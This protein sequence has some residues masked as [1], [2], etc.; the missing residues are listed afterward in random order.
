VTSSTKKTW[1]Y[2]IRPIHIDG[3]VAFIPLT[4]GKT[5]IIDAADVDLVKDYNWSAMPTDDPEKW[6]AYNGGNRRIRLQ[7]VILPAPKGFITDHKNRDGL[8]CRRS[9]LRIATR[10]QNSQNKPRPRI[11]IGDFKGVSQHG[12]GWRARIVVDYTRISL[13]IFPSAEAAARAYDDAA[14]EH[15]GE[16]AVLNFGAG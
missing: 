16:F 9:N 15:F 10:Q 2:K 12:S 3:E 5:A 8:D 1:R 6:Y 11:G 7:Q 14:A 4:R 13:G